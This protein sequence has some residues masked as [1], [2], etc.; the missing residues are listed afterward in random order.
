MT[1]FASV[2]ERAAKAARP[3]P[4]VLAAF[5]GSLLASL[6]AILTS[7]GTL[8]RDGMLYIDAARLFLEGGVA[9][10]QGVF[11]WP[12]LPI[13]IA[14]VSKATGLGLEAAGHTL[15]ALFMAG[16]CA[17]VVA[18]S[19][20]LYPNTAWIAVLTVLAIPGLND[21]RNE[22]LREYGYWF[23]VML[24]F[25]LALRWSEALRWGMALL[26]QASIVIASLF[27][28]EALAFLP[29]LV[30]WQIFDAP[31]QTR[32]KRVLML[33]V[34][35][36]VGALTLLVLAI[37][38]LLPSRLA[39]D[40]GRL[41]INRFTETA[42]GIAPALHPFARENAGAILLFGS[43]ALI[44]FKFAKM[45]G[46][47]ILPLLFALR[48]EP[49]RQLRVLGWAFLAHLAVLAVFVTDLHFLAGRYVATLFFF[50]APL[51]AL[52]LQIIIQRWQRL[53][54]PLIALAL[55][56]ALSNAI[57]LAPG[58][59]HFVAAGAWLAQNAE[60]TP[61]VYNESARAAYYAG[62]RYETSTM[63]S[64]RNS[65]P[66]ALQRNEL[67][68]VV[69]EVSRQDADFPDWFANSGLREV[70]RFSHANGDSVVIATPERSSGKAPE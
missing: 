11:G 39:G 17:L 25:W 3:I 7:A 33:G 48:R 9:A 59:Q 13:L 20:R 37:A 12:F 10:A 30:I 18:C 27:R 63:R 69:L 6:L 68:L 32:T 46:V 49:L 44:P 58:K 35:A 5:A 70:V 61:R 38:G 28:P 43:L 36:A 50:A 56:L 26:I 14:L 51:M 29:A 53:K 31:V 62:W 57:S 65:L 52:G 47:F 55:V 66:E 42:Q 2:T 16:A 23:F 8:N 67:D 54:L 34:L 64:G 41:S 1:I 4:P 21:Y 24:A 45:A 40:F 60:D 19:S 22:L 15:S